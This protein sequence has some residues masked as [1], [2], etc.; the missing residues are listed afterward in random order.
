MESGGIILKV[1]NFP[2]FLSN[3]L[4]AT[5]W[6]ASRSGSPLTSFKD[7]Y[8]LTS[9]HCLWNSTSVN[10]QS[11]LPTSQASVWMLCSQGSPLYKIR[12]LWCPVS[13]SALTIIC[14]VSLFDVCLPQQPRRGIKAVIMYVLF[15]IIVPVSTTVLSTYQALNQ[16]IL[17]ESILLC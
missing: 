10:F 9:F 7:I 15:I 8:I 13:L 12:N 5:K 14:S 2:F 11:V 17:S 3:L 1:V 6:I 4:R 16:G